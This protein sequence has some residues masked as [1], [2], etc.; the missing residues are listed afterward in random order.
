MATIKV[1][2]RSSRGR[3]PHKGVIYL[4][5]DEFE[6]DEND[7]NVKAAIKIRLLRKVHE[8]KPVEEIPESDLD[9]EDVSN[10]TGSI[11]ESDQATPNVDSKEVEEPKSEE[12]DKKETPETN[13]KPPHKKK[14]KSK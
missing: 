14:E 6:V 13:K 5:G 2:L 4:H 1:T 9:S 3:Y 10:D 8:D 12:P 7:K 11:E